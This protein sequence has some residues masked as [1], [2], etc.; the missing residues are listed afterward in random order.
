MYN[1]CGRLTL[2]Y[3][4]RMKI[5]ALFDTVIHDLAEAANLK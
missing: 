1:F 2:V 3:Q 5:R 4:L